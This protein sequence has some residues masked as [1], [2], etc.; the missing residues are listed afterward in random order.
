MKNIVSIFAFLLMLSFLNIGCSSQS[1]SNLTNEAVAELINSG[2]FTF[3]AERATP[4]DLDAVRIMNNSFPGGSNRIMNLDSGYN[5]IV[6]KEK[7]V[8]HL[9][10]FGRSFVA[11]YDTSKVGYN[12]T[13]EKFTVTKTA[14]KKNSS[15][16]SFNIGDQQYLKKMFLQV[17]PNGKAYLSIDS[18]DRQPISYDGYIEQND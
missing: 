4:T 14:G 9:P 15:L 16:F 7:I 5:L 11:S 3:V 12:F 6:T 18:S 13:S 8:A 10:Y 17:Y 1:N 2:S